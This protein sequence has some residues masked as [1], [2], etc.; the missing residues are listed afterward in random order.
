MNY[1]QSFDIM[2]RVAFTNYANVLRKKGFDVLM[3]INKPFENCLTFKLDDLEQHID[4]FKLASIDFG[5]SI[6]GP[7]VQ[8]SMKR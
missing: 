1:E 6:N 7:A 2:K 5:D 8:A 3:L 4:D